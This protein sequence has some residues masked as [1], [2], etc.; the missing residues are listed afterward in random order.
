MTSQSGLNLIASR[1]QDI[2]DKDYIR[3]GKPKISPA[4]LILCQ[5]WILCQNQI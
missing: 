4:V 2:N 1:S 3:L 5:V